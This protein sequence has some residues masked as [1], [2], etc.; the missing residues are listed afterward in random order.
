[1]ESLESIP[2]DITR[3][4]Y[5]L[6][7]LVLLFLG[8]ECRAVESVQLTS[9]FTTFL[10]ERTN[11]PAVAATDALETLTGA[12]TNLPPKTVAMPEWIGYSLLSIGAVLALH[13]L[14]MGKPD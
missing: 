9:E 12:K 5:F 13:A 14:A 3:N 8:I 10:A 4:Q 11:H 2:M 6:A 7:G 1:M